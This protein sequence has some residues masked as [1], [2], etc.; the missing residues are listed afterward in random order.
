MGA[1]GEAPCHSP[2]TGSRYCFPMRVQ[3]WNIRRFG[4]KGRLTLLKDYPRLHHID[5]VCLQETRKQHITDLELRSL[6]IWEKLFWCWLPANGQLGGML[7]G[8]QDSLFEVE[9]FCTGQSFLLT[10]ALFRPSN[11]KVAIM[12]IYG[13]ADHS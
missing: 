4:S 6:E 8:L 7:L 9:S 11:L 2:S 12:G 10:Q 3:F 13:P 5:I 1:S